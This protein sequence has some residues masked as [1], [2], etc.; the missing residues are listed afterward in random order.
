MVVPP[1]T[2]DCMLPNV[3]QTRPPAT[4]PN[5]A[6]SPSKRIGSIPT[7]LPGRVDDCKSDE[8]HV[9]GKGGVHEWN[10]HLFG[11]AIAGHLQYHL[12]KSNALCTYVRPH[13]LWSTTKM[14]GT[15]V[16]VLQVSVPAGVPATH[17]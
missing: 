3:A 13:V 9:A 15:K 6:Q 17:H 7:V 11:M 16:A 4:V 1:T 14:C 5:R 8:L 12:A 10:G 2:I